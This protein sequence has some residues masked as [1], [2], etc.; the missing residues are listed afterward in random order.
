MAKSGISVLARSG[1]K[2][3]RE[4][5]DIP[6]LAAGLPGLDRGLEFVSAKPVRGHPRGDVV[7]VSAR[8]AA[9]TVGR[10]GFPLSG[11]AE[12]KFERCGR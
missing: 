3:P 7:L 11:P 12:D 2:P 9:A 4:P 5:A 8:I 1:S 10:S 6:P